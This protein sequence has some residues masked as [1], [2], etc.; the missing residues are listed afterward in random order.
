[1]GS[2]SPSTVSNWNPQQGNLAHTLAPV[3]QGQVGTGVTPYGGQ[4]V[5]PLNSGYGQVQNQINSFNPSQFQGGQ[6]GAINQAL[7]GKPAYQLDPQTTAN[8]YQKS[9]VD[10]SM[11]NYN[12]VTAP[13]INENF[14]QAG[15]TFSTTRGIAQSRALSSLQ[16]NNATQ[17][18]QAQQQNQSINANLADTAANMQLQGVGAAQQYA[19]QPLY[20]AQQLGAALAPF[21]QNAQSMDDA[22]YQQWQQS[23]SYNNPYLQQ[24]MAYLGQSSQSAY[25]KPDYTGQEIGLGT[26]VAGGVIGAIYGGPMGAIQGFGTGYSLGNTGYNVATGGGTAALNPTY[27]KG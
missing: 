11:R 25:Q 16:S 8:L 5:A 1:M 2:G 12:S 24:I 9:I 20:N 7:S 22:S 26:G 15:G 23:Q 14:A 19:N 10:P 4:L 17:L 18:S 27:T 21:Q 3:L 13:S 6:S